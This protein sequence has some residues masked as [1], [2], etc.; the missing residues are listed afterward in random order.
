LILYGP[1]FYLV[2]N[3]INR[4]SIGDRTA[5]MKNNADGSLEIQ[6]QQEAPE[7]GISNWL[8]APSGPFQLILRTYQP[9]PALFN[10][11]YQVPPIQ[12]V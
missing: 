11:D 10:G 1:D 12:R 8:P 2:E 7:D 3:P 5:G 9:R 6:I 4:Y